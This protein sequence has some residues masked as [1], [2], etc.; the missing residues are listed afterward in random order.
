MRQLPSR[1]CISPLCSE[2]AVRR[3]RCRHHASLLPT[4]RPPAERGYTSAYQRERL[5]YIGKPCELR[6]DERCT[7]I[8]TTAD[9]YELGLRA[10]C[11]MCNSILGGMKGARGRGV[12][13]R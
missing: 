12:A 7:G 2:R 13:R 5:N 3:S 10:A 11:G 9:H 4:E 1:Q 8:A 6:V